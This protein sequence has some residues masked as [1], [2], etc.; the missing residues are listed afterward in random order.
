LRPDLPCARRCH[1]AGHHA[2]GLERAREGGLKLQRH[3]RDGSFAEQSRLPT[4]NVK[5]IGP[6]DPADAGRWCALGT[7]LVPYG[8]LMAARLQ[9]GETVLVSG[10]T[11]NFGSAAVLLALAMGAAWVIAPGRNAAMLAALARR[12]GPRVRTVQLTGDEAEDT[13]RMNEAAPGPI[14]CVL[15]IL[16]PEAP[17]SAARAAI[18]AVRPYGR[19]ALMGGV[20]M[21]GGENLALSYAWIMRNCVTIA[22]QWMYAPD[23]AL[24][25]AAM[26]RAGALDLGHFEVTAFGLDQVNVAVDH[27]AA[28]GGPFR[29]TVLNLAA[30][31]AAP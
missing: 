14:D 10:A 26:I 3:F 8:G 18:M 6:I 7:L 19:V 11:G 23:A 21:Q 22:G 15:D 4:E 28:N 30:A 29:M 5:P 13:R 1:F 27:A 20:G 24:R 31:S 25:L 12:F 9:A 16:P 17:A 2:A